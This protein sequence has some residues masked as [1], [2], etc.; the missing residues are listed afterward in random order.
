METIPTWDGLSRLAVLGVCFLV[1][2]LG[3][4]FFSVLGGESLELLD[5]LQRYFHLAGYGGGLDPTLLSVVWDI[6]RWPLMAFLLGFTALGMVGIP[7]LLLIRG[8][9]LSFAATTFVRLF[10]LPGL[11]ASLAAFGVTVLL[12]V[13]VLFVV[14]L[15]SFRQSL[16]RLPGSSLPPTPWDYRAA[17]LAPCAGL[18]VLATALQRTVM[19]AVFTAVCARLFAL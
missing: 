2:V 8:F 12:T 1:G 3:G 6:F 9:L 16:D 4:F 10:G 5:Y 13:P 18:L 17:V 14:S 19:P 15:D 11:A 7:L